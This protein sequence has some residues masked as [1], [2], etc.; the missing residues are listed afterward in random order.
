MAQIEIPLPWRLA[1]CNV[2]RTGK[3]GREIIWTL[4]ASQRFEA[5]F[6]GAWVYQAHDDFRR[7][8]SLA[9]VTGCPV[10]M[11]KPVGTT[12]E[13]MFDLKN[14]SSY[15]KIL[16]VQ[17]KKLIYIFSAHLPLKPKLSCE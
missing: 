6:S 12:Y 10:T 2:L 14:R 8:L 7:H 4:D 13:F 16:L 5:G 17:D 3:S 15:G 9:S 11:A 1:V